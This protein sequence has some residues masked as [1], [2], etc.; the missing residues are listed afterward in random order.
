M[1]E[2]PRE[3]AALLYSLS[4]EQDF[5][6]LGKINSGL[7]W[8][9]QITILTADVCRQVSECVEIVVKQLSELN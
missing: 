7:I 2:T 5:S 4:S 1:A 6:T 8:S 3:N 9:K